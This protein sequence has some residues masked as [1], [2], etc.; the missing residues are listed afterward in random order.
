[1]SSWWSV[2]CRINTINQISVKSACQ[3]N[4]NYLHVTAHNDWSCIYMS[5][6]TTTDWLTVYQLTDRSVERRHLY[7]LSTF[8]CCVEL[9]D[10][11]STCMLMCLLY[12]TRSCSVHVISRWSTCETSASRFSSSIN[13]SSICISHKTSSS[14][15]QPLT[16][17]PC[18]YTSLMRRR[19][20]DRQVNDQRVDV[21]AQRAL[22]WMW[23]NYHFNK[24]RQLGSSHIS[25]TAW[26]IQHD[27]W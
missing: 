20:L 10:E 1:M 13:T 9:A 21:C 8:C 17:Q 26:H 24:A 23:N 27:I 22:H 25:N 2:K 18:K 7:R 5:Q 12:V 15:L 3:V 4:F 14:T 6:H 11:L 16:T 19:R